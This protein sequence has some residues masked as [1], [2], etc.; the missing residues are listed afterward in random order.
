MAEDF[1]YEGMMLHH[2]VTGSDYF[3]VMQFHI[4]EEHDP[5]LVFACLFVCFIV[6]GSAVFYL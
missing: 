5:H 2:W 1:V 3:P 4:P 6:S